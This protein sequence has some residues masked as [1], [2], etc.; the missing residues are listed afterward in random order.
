MLDAPQLVQPGRQ[1]LHLT[2]RRRHDYRYFLAPAV[3]GEES[4][5]L[6]Y[7]GRVEVM[8][9]I[10]ITGVGAVANV[11]LLS[12]PLQVGLCLPSKFCYSLVLA[13][14]ERIMRHGAA[15]GLV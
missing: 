9:V 7:L 6:R 8:R 4:R 5:V 15:V 10:H 3:S 12:H 11:R 13:G 14:E 1:V 2:L